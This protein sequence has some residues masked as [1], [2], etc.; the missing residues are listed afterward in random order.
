VAIETHF[1]WVLAGKRAYKLKK[2]LRHAKQ[3]LA[4][5]ERAYRAELRL[6]MRLAPAVHL[7]VPP[8]ARGAIGS[9]DF[10]GHERIVDWLVVLLPASHM[11]E[12]TIK[13]GTVGHLHQLMV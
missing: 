3:T 10:V 8:L 2:P 11:L 4:Q 1:A 7:Q 9:L 5:R 13:D 6:N 12:Q